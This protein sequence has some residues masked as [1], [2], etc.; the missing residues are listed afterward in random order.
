[1][2]LRSE[3]LLRPDVV[4]L[5]HGSYGACPRPVFEAYQ[6]W[7]RE[8]ELQPVEFL[9]R[10]GRGLLHTAREAL[11]AY[12]GAD[13]DDLAFMA[14]ATTGLNTV[15]RALPLAEGDEVLGTDH[16]YGAMERTWEFVCRK[17]GARYVRQPVP[18]PLASPQEVVDAV[19][20]GVTPR[21]R[22]LFISH[23]TSPTALTFPVADLVRRAREAGII[24]VVDGAHVPGQ[25][26]LDLRALGAD[27]YC[28]NGHKWLNSP[29]GSGFLYARRDVQPL[30]TPLV[31]SW[32]WREDGP[33]MGLAEALEGQGT[34]DI[35]AFLAVPAA[36]AFQEQ[37]D[38]PRVRT[39]CHALLQRAR[40]AI[41]DLTGL[42]PLTPDSPDWY[43]QMA[44]LPLPPCDAARLKQRLY[45]EHTVEVPIITWRDRQFVRI[46]VQAYNTWSDLDTLV[47]A[48]AT[49][50]PET[51]RA[52]G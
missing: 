26:P 24:S 11:A 41:G 3:F 48:L 50:L 27:F 21:T 6:A 43:A 47:E 39:E 23:I 19:W 49:L 28:G 42:P 2:T 12:V 44:A 31:I 14:N 20:A 17:S 34:R 32:G 16:E 45:D 1:M 18:V 5:N 52:S 15:A 13:P 37:H 10:R 36:I 25:R 40:S 9:G 51:A 33:V 8:L 29:K 38:W 30:L 35:A 7:Q 22:V 4:F 46:S